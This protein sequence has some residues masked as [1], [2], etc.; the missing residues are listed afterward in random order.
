MPFAPRF[1]EVGETEFIENL[2]FVTHRDMKTYLDGFYAADNLPDFAVMTDGEIDQFTYPLINFGIERMSSS[3]TND[4]F[5]VDQDL[6]IG[7]GM[8]ISDSTSVKN[9]KLKARKYVRAFKSVVRSAP[10]AD[11]LPPSARIM[12]CVIDVDHQYFRHKVK[13]GVFVQPVE[14]RL[15]FRFGE[16]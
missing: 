9:V 3:E 8:L 2:M 1:Q 6:I 5:Y 12:G 7:A 4:G 13:E 16:N 11:L 14:F 10:N 15:R